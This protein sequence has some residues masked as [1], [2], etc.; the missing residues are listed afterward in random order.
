MRVCHA[1]TLLDECFVSAAASAEDCKCSRL[2]PVLL[3]KS[4]W[5]SE[6][7]LC[8]LVYL[9]T[10]PSKTTKQMKQL[11]TVIEVMPQRQ[12]VSSDFSLPRHSHASLPLLSA[13]FDANFAQIDSTFCRYRQD[14]R[15]KGTIFCDYLGLFMFCILRRYR[16]ELSSSVFLYLQSKQNLRKL[17]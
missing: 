5:Y 10:N 12:L 3:V 14:L 2:Y 11:V 15:E 8:V 9:C 13:S 17:S 16:K 6:K 1:Q 4:V 7:F